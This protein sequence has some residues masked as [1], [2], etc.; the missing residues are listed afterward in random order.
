MGADPS[1]RFLYSRCKGLVEED[2]ASLGYAE[3]IIFRPGILS[4]AQ[5]DSR[6]ALE[7][8]AV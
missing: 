4:G 7:G 1:S 6:G 2:L 3:T 8:L 5:R